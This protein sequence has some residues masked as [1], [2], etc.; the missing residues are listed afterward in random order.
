MRS[1]KTILLSAVA[2]LLVLFAVGLLELVALRFEAGDIY[3]PYSTLRSDPLGAKAFY[4]SLAALDGVSVR[5]NYLP[6]E[7]LLPLMQGPN[8]EALVYLGADEYSQAASLGEKKP[9]DYAEMLDN[10]VAPGG[11]LVVA[12]APDE[13]AVTTSQP[14]AGTRSQT[15]PAGAHSGANA[16]GHTMRGLMAKLG[17]S[18]SAGRKI[19]AEDS[20]AVTDEK[21]L[22]TAG[23][24]SLVEPLTWKSDLYFEIADKSWATILKRD[25]HPVIIERP[26]GKGSVVL[27]SDSYFVSNEAML[28][29]RRPALLSWLLG[30]AGEIVFDETH[31]GSVQETGLAAL[32]RK[33][34]M[35]YVALALLIVGVLAIW[36]GNSSFVPRDEALV[37]GLSGGEVAGKGSWAAMVNLL[38]TAIGPGEIMTTCLAEWNKA[39]GRSPTAS[40]RQAIERANQ[41]LAARGAAKEDVKVT[42]N[43]L[44][45]AVGP[46]G[47]RPGTAGSDI[48]RASRP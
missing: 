26:F 32:A 13:A 44:C 14:S 24:E 31:L 30:S 21:A 1:R 33:Y 15:R 45:Q 43:E 16:T 27:C 19:S 37:A 41:V 20:P 18:L 23:N 9:R 34:N 10:F 2:V 8:R 29:Q 46:R 3:P 25:G 36:R 7:Q 47:G 40:Q 6:Q 11:R 48:A 4:D 22:P 38:R 17:A 39:I 12:F 5:R 28:N 35:G 42:Y